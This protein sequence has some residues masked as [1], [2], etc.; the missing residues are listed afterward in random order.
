MGKRVGNRYVGDRDGLK[1]GDVIFNEIQWDGFNGQ[2]EAGVNP[3]SARPCC[4]FANEEFIELLNTTFGKPIDLS[5]WTIASDDDFVT[6]LVSGDGHWALRAIP[7][8]W[9]KTRHRMMI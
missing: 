1:V 2:L 6:R 7:Y 8:F 9:L 4:L 5:M 3:D